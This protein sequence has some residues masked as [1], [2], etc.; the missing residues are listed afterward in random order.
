MSLRLRLNL[1]LLACF[2]VGLLGS[3]AY[4]RYETSRLTSEALEYEARLHMQTALAVREFVIERV[5]PTIDAAGD[6]AFIPA[7]VP[8]FAAHET[9]ALL[10]RDYPGYRYRETALNPINPANLATGWEREMI[11][12][13]R[14]GSLQGE[15]IRQQATPQGRFVTV[16]RPITITDE[17]CLHCHGDPAKA[18][19][20]MRRLY[21]GR[22]GFGWKMGETI[23]AQLVSVP[24]DMQ[25]RRANVAFGHFLVALAG[26]FTLLFVA[27]NVLLSRI[28]LLPLSDANSALDRLADT[29]ALTGLHNRR[30]LD[31]CLRQALERDAHAAQPLSL[32]M[33]DIDHFK[34]VNDAFGHDAGDDAL[35]AVG[36][37]ARR[38]LR[39][40]DMLARIGGE[41]FVV[42]L[43]Q[44]DAA[45]AAL[46]AEDLRLQVRATD[47]GR[48]GSVTASFGV[49]QWDGREDAAAL[50]ARAD[51]ALYRAKHAGRDR[52]ETS[53]PDEGPDAGPADATA[54]AAR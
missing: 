17:A 38:R 7:A 13:F 25:E 31:R 42:L 18:P 45:G 11:D 30:A 20:A 4:Y 46:V 14:D 51:A 12:R 47:A 52:V 50:L 15:Q 54:L 26:V 16:T 43:P 24:A 41:E 35:R 33:F 5:K 39:H 9:L 19:A 8:A 23:G 6:E 36:A 1:I 48:A 44:T 29:D 3:A 22:G 53:R 40:H 49:A 37:A 28:V 2:G 32:V 21:P 27:L 34:R 10:Y